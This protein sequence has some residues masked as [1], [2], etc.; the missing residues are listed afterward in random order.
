MCENKHF[1]ISATS[2]L[3]ML[4]CPLRFFYERIAHVEK[5]QEVDIDRSV[6]LK[7]NVK[8]MYIHEIMENYAKVVLKGKSAAEVS[9]TVDKA[10]L[11]E[12]FESVTKNT[13]LIIHRLI[14]LLRRVRERN[15]TTVSKLILTNCTAIYTQANV[16]SLRSSIH[17][18][19]M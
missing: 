8:G 19:V 10:M 18:L 6:W 5:P 12:I 4:Q 11:D 14:W 15:I 1:I 13:F 2:L 3:A 17:L 16:R 9:E 7:G